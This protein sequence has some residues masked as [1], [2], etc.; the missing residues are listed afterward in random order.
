MRDRID[1]ERHSK[2]RQLRVQGHEPFSAAHLVSRS[3]AAAIQA[4]HD[5]R[6]L[7]PGEHH[8]WRY[9]VAGRLVA[10]RKHRHATFFDLRDQ[11]GVIELSVKRDRQGSGECSL[12]ISAD[13]GDIVAVEG[14]VYVTDNHRLT[15]SVLTAELLTKALRSPPPH[16]IDRAGDDQSRRQ[17]ELSLLVN[18]RA[19][20]LVEIRSSV[21]EATRA[22]MTE[23]LFIEVGESRFRIHAGGLDLRRCL[24]GGLERVYG[25]RQYSGG[26]ST[27][28]EWATAYIEYH[29]AAKQVEALIRHVAHVVSPRAFKFRSDNVVDFEPPWRSTT[30]R[31]AIMKEC[32]LDVI[33]L[34]RS[35]LAGWISPT[36]RTNDESWGALV[37]YI[38]STHVEPKLINPTIVYDFPLSDQAFARRHP[39]HDELACSF[40]LVI[41]GIE[42]ARGRTELNDPQEQRLRLAAR[43]GT[44]L[45]DGWRTAGHLDREVRLLEYGM[46]PAACA[47]LEID[48]LSMLIMKARPTGVEPVSAA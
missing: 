21:A 32:G 14:V 10:R 12:L 9:T 41:G 1:R 39:T 7:D 6:M 42:M 2:L 22:W 5:P 11:S 46:T 45:D 30:V 35:E 25:M 8:Q 3:L 20:L 29:E 44:S 19:R 33:T 28:L 23:N 34:Q 38:Y 48:R 43:D 27:T 18:E 4:E 16:R 13:L 36:P 37:N 40:A 31:D 24:L 17:H 15:I 47:S 26:E